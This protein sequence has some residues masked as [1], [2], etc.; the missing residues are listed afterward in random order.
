MPHDRTIHIAR[1]YGYVSVKKTQQGKGHLGFNVDLSIPLGPRQARQ[2]R[3]E[4]LRALRCVFPA[5]P[6]IPLAPSPF[7]FCVFPLAHD[8]SHLG[9]QRHDPTNRYPG[10]CSETTC[11]VPEEIAR[12][13]VK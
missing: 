8:M 10:I 1:T 2:P 9:R 13:V 6:L 5:L 4:R 7:F 11:D 3:A 12:P